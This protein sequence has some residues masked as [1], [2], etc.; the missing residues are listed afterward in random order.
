MVRNR[1]P[2]AGGANPAL[3]RIVFGCLVLA[4]STVATLVLWQVLEPGGIVWINAVLLTLFALLFTWIC[5][6]FWTV[7]IGYGV[8]LAARLGARSRP[9]VPMEPMEWAGSHSP[10]R[11]ALLVP[12]FNEDIAAV[13]ARIEA[14]YRSFRD[15]GS[16][17]TFDVFILSD[18]IDPEIWVQEEIA[19][20]A[21]CRK[22]PASS[23]IFY[24]H[25]PRNT[26]FKSGNIADFCRRWGRR[27]RYMIVLDADSL[28]S[29]A[30]MVE[31]VRRMDGNPRCGLIQTFPVPIRGRTLL[32]RMQQFAANLYGPAH[33]AGAAFWQLGEGNYW[34]HN[35]IIRV[36]PFMQHCGLPRLPGRRPFGGQILSHDFVEAA[37]LVRAGWEVTLAP[38]LGESYEEVP[39]TLL[40]NAQRDRRW[41][42]GNLQHLRPLLAHGLRPMSRLH[43]ITGIMTYVASPLWLIF[44]VISTA[45][46]WRRTNSEHVYFTESSFFP[47]WPISH[48]MEAQLLLGATLAILFL[49]KLIGLL[50]LVTDGDRVARFGGR[51]AASFGALA[52]TTLSALVA[53]VLM[54]FHTRFV[55]LTLLGRDTGW[56]PQQ[57]G[58]TRAP[59]LVVVRAH[60]E[61]VVGGL[62]AAIAANYFVPESLF[63]LSPVLAGPIL[64]VPL[65]LALSSSVL[66]QAAGRLF[67]VPSESRPSPLV[68]MFEA[69][70]KDK[71]AAQESAEG[72]RALDRLLVDPH[73]NA[74]HATLLSGTAGTVT[75]PRGS[76]VRRAARHGISSLS[77]AEQW[78]AL[79]DAG[80]VM[81]MHALRQ[82]ARPSARP[83]LG[84]NR[85]E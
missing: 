63:W 14:V 24:R 64:A 1:V 75:R 21:L 83:D 39:P 47:L 49:P 20:L 78:E 3:R 61:H 73:V 53:P 15:T 40:A 74:L 34:G 50:F 54:A 67:L 32:A 82:R 72:D 19:W 13:F 23:R 41:C 17:D 52:E 48:A 22:L 62:G 4:S 7:M 27:Y 42:Q 43:L 56:I 80:S 70:L 2:A 81:W 71:T 38:D 16:G 26:E 31:L 59:L 11:T 45:D 44:I 77:T 51:V 58:R 68:R 9:S 85:G 57:R 66:G 76:L 37:L 46:L 69:A 30:T 18:T 12:I 35:A 25:R 29:G 33:V 6:S 79:S 8:L 84:R 36:A 5:V 60:A 10:S 65:S 55:I 28:M